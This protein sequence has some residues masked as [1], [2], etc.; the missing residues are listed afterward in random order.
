MVSLTAIGRKSLRRMI[1]AASDGTT[2]VSFKLIDAST[3]DPTTG[4]NVEVAT[5]Q[6]V[7]CFL[8]RGEDKATKVGGVVDETYIIVL[9]DGVLPRVPS[10]QDEVTING[11]RYVVVSVKTDP[12]KVQ[13]KIEV[14]NA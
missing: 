10:D 2:L 11:E 12:M 7:K 8:M 4:Q 1:N 5:T 3:Y 6:D 14:I 9:E 13:L